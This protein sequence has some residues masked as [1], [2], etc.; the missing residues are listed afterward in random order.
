V[1]SPQQPD[2]AEAIGTAQ[3]LAAALDGMA[4][5]LAEVNASSETRDA[6]LTRYGRAN[7]HR[8]WVTYALLAVDVALT[9]VVAFLAVQAGNASSRAE[10]ATA[11]AAAA[12]A[13][14]SALHTAQ[15]SGCV[16]GNQERSGELALWTYLFHASTPG[17]AAQQ[18][19]VALFM[20]QVD[21]TF[22]PRDCAKA[23]A[24][25]PAKGAQADGSR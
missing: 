4:E 9:I 11:R 5:R 8:I 25:T 16:A 21:R 2:P 14:E 15:V 24:L 17:D 19:A 18:K 22:S 3:T 13:A 12:T 10:S 20:Q 7:R 1:P 6:D 23:Y